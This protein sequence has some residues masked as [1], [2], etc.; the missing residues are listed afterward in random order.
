[1]S[2]A[3]KR[4]T[5]ADGPEQLEVKT[6]ETLKFSFEICSEIVDYE[7]KLS[8]VEPISHDEDSEF[9]IRGEMTGR[10]TCGSFFGFYDAVSGSGRIVFD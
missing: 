3:H 1:M 10:G 8:L 2:T 7:I 6:G 4:L 9:L 5:I